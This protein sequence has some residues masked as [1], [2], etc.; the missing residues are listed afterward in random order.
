M[1]E[2]KVNNT[3]IHAD[4]HEDDAP[5]ELYTDQILQ[6]QKGTYLICEV[7]LRE[8]GRRSNFILLQEK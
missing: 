1:D 5:Y 6:G 7:F 8:D 4:Y 2:I 3:M